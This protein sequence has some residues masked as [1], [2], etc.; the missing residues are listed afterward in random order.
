MRN[1]LLET[2]GEASEQINHISPEY[3]TFKRFEHDSDKVGC[4]EVEA[5]L[6]L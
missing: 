4:P 1:D 5:S 2:T 6:L 3:Q